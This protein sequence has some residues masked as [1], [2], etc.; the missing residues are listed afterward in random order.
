V[1]GAA[2]G[3]VLAS[4]AGTLA[5]LA[6][7][8]N[9][10]APTLAV[11]TWVVVASATFGMDCFGPWVDS[12][13]R[14]VIRAR[15]RLAR[16]AACWSFHSCSFRGACFSSMNL[17]FG[18]LGHPG[19]VGEVGFCGLAG[20]GVVWRRGVLG[21]LPNRVPALDFELHP[22][23]VFHRNMERGGST[24]ARFRSIVFFISALMTSISAYWMDSSS[25]MSAM[26]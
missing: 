23:G 22:A 21:N 14:G 2:W 17:A 11:P 1:G 25:S 20:V 16:M 4:A 26:G 5:S 10:S 3:D 7:R 6:G 12:S 18:L 13:L 15:S 8:T 24:P 9:A 19:I